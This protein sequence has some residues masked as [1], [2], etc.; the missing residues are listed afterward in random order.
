ME[1]SCIS[2]DLLGE[3]ASLSEKEAPEGRSGVDFRAKLLDWGGPSISAGARTCIREDED[4]TSPSVPP[5]RTAKASS[6]SCITDSRMSSEMAVM[7]A[8]CSSSPSRTLNLFASSRRR[9]MS[10]DCSSMTVACSS[11]LDDC[12][13]MM[14]K[15]L[16]GS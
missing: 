1:G 6:R 3:V 15:S 13:S 4:A 5:S 12:S 8:I 11:I 14:E 16:W 7:E 2:G 10:T 9:L